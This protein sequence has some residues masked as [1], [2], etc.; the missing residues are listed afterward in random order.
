[1]TVLIHCT[2]DAPAISASN[3]FVVTVNTNASL[4]RNTLVLGAAVA[5][6]GTDGN[7]ADNSDSSTR[8]VHF[9]RDLSSDVQGPGSMKVGGRYR[10][11]VAIANNGSADENTAI[12][13]LTVNGPAALVESLQSGTVNCAVRSTRADQ[14]VWTC[15]PLNTAPVTGA[16][17]GGRS[18]A[19]QLT[20]APSFAQS[21]STVSV[22]SVFANAL[23]ANSDDPDLTNNSDT[24][25]AFVQAVRVLPPTVPGQPVRQD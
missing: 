4:D 24:M 6:N 19:L 16:Y 25:S 10:F 23:N 14:T 17:Q 15:V 1:L 18:D 9:P 7:P 20:I 12:L 3:V 21:G 8:Y 11:D 13:Y 2:S 5:S 22:S